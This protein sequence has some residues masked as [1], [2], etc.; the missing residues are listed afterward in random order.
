[1]YIL[2]NYTYCAMGKWGKTYA[3]YGFIFHFVPLHSALLD[4]ETLRI[5]FEWIA[6]LNTSKM[7]NRHKLY[8]YH[9]MLPEQNSYSLISVLSIKIVF[10]ITAIFLA[11]N[12]IFGTFFKTIINDFELWDNQKHKLIKTFRPLVIQLRNS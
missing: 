9:T 4:R 2:W 3:G 11:S 1:M 7:N 6:S 10:V 5:D 12:A 8:F